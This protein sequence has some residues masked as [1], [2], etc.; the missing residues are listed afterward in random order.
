MTETQ[1]TLSIAQLVFFNTTP[2]TQNANRTEAPLPVFYWT[3]RPCKV[4]EWRNGGCA[5]LGLSVNYRC[6]KQ[7]YLEKKMGVFVRQQFTDEGVVSPPGLRRG[8][9]IQRW[10]YRQYRSQSIFNNLSR[11]FSM[12]L[13]NRCGSKRSQQ[14]KSSC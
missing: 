1:A 7:A 5:I 6:V 8:L 4:H 3:Q 14:N 12:A 10:R 9:S 13:L 11:I 2:N